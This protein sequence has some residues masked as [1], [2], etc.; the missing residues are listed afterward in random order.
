VRARLPVG[1]KPCRGRARDEDEND[2]QDLKSEFRFIF[3]GWETS[4]SMVGLG[5]ASCWVRRPRSWGAGILLKTW[6]NRQLP[7]RAPVPRRRVE[8]CQLRDPR[9]RGTAALQ[10]SA[11]L[12]TTSR[13]GSPCGVVALIL[14]SPHVSHDQDIVSNS[15]V[16]NGIQPIR[17]PNGLSSL[18]PDTWFVASR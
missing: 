5:A 12:A 11:N 2:S 9:L 17:V 8:R 14:M 15:S 10:A 4:G 13:A 7:W 6:A 16:S 3:R 1:Q 18:S